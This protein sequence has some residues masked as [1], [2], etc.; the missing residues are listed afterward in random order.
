M[1]FCSAFI[2]SSRGTSSVGA[3]ETKLYKALRLINTLTT[4]Q[5][6]GPSYCTWQITDIRVQAALILFR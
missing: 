3:E 1:L 5:I 4:M 6:N 2:T